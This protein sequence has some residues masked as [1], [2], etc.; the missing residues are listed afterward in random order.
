MFPYPNASQGFIQILPYLNSVSNNVFGIFLSIT[1]VAILW[2]SF[3]R[4]AKERALLAASF[5]GFITNGLLW[6]G[7]L[8]NAGYPL[9]MFL[10]VVVSFIFTYRSNN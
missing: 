5:V 9:F 8:V 3:A 4:Y 7:G 1:F 2:L 6:A 10:I